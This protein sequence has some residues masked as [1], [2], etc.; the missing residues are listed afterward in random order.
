M[1][2]IYVAGKYLGKTHAET[3]INIDVARKEAAFIW[4]RGAVAICPHLNSAW[5]S[6]ICDEKYFYDGYIELVKRCDALYACWNWT[7]SKGSKL[8]LEIAKE[9]GLPVL[10]NRMELMNY[11]QTS[12]EWDA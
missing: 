12:T 7:D 10:Y 4:S 11:L 6:G 3:Y 2:V 8:E 5:M 9:I 1:K